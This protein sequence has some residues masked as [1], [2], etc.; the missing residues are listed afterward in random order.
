MPSINEI[1]TSDELGYKTKS[2]RFIWL[3]CN[4][5]GIER[6]V[7]LCKGKPKS[8][9][10]HKCAHTLREDL[11][12]FWKG[13]KVGYAAL[14]EWIR[15]RKPKP[16]FCEICQIKKPIDMA[17]MDGNYTRDIATW[18]WLC[19]TCH[20]TIDGR[21]NKMHVGLPERNRRRVKSF[22]MK[23]IEKEIEG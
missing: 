15:S 5:C 13:D 8:L 17:N 18:K 14:H 4:Q 9:L 19:R 20:M 1:R 21:L 6:W 23:Q 10:C 7:I 11:N 22:C 16:L 12:H 3:P 2:H